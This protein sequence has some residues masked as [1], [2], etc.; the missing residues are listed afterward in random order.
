MEKTQKIGRIPVK[1]RKKMKLTLRFILEFSIS[2]CK[3]VDFENFR[4]FS[5]FELYLMKF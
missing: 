3:K 5:G 1:L 2:I 4:P